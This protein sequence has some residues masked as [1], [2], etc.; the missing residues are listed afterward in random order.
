MIPNRTRSRHEPGNLPAEPEPGQ[1]PPGR[2]ER[3]WDRGLPGDDVT[4]DWDRDD[5]PADLPGDDSDESDDPTP[6][7]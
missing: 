6:D 2:P 5:D 3:G 1:E 4:P 7:W